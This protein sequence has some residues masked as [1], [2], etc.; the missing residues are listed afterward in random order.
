[1]QSPLAHVI[2]LHASSPVHE[3]V[4]SPLPVHVTGPQTWL[5]LPSLHVSMQVPPLEQLS[6]PHAPAPLH[7]SSHRRPPQSMLPHGAAAVQLYLHWKPAGHSPAPLTVHSAGDIAMSQ[8][9]LH[10]AGHSNASGGRGASIGS[11]PVTQ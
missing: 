8:P 3:R 10:A 7:D 9:P 11:V 4:Q 2:A 1:V 5:P 6:V